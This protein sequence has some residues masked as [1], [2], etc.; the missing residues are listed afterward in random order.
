MV[1]DSPWRYSN[2]QAPST[3]THGGGG[4]FRVSG[5]RGWSETFPAEPRSSQGGA[6]QMR[7][8]TV[9]SDIGCDGDSRTVRPSSCGLIWQ[10]MYGWMARRPR[11]RALSRGRPTEAGQCGQRRTR[12]RTAQLVGRGGARGVVL[13]DQ[14]G[15]ASSTSSTVP[16]ASGAGGSADRLAV[17]VAV[18]GFGECTIE[19]TATVAINGVESF[20]CD[21]HHSPATS[22]PTEGLL[23]RRLDLGGRLPPASARPLTTEQPRWQVRLRACRSAGPFRDAQEVTA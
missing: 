19:G 3:V 2:R 6:L 14:P 17:V 21:G 20:V 22:P 9:A 12:T 15:V 7:D 10:L 5:R 11:H 4:A 8:L 23:G 16:Q 18:D 13:V 1:L